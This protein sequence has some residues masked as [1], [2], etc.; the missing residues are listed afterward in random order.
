MGHRTRYSVPKQLSRRK[1]KNPRYTYH[2]LGSFYIL[3]SEFNMPF[4][5]GPFGTLNM[6]FSP[7]PFSALNV[8]F[9]PGPFGTLYVPFSPGPFGTLYVPFS[10]GP[11][12]TLL[13]DI[14]GSS[15]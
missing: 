3:L 12:G 13:F 15:S 14:G 4:S 5:P 6:P 11:F 9:S 10:P 1:L 7:G 8:P 2:T